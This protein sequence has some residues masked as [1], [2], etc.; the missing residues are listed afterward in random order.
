MRPAKSRGNSY[1]FLAPEIYTTLSRWYG[2]KE[3]IL[4]GI[5]L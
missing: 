5:V 1:P 4:N 3:E 2:E